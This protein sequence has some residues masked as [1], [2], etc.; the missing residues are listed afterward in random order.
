[1]ACPPATTEWT[2][3][4]RDRAAK[5]PRIFV[6]ENIVPQR[7]KRCGAG[8]HDTDTV[9]LANLL[10]QLVESLIVDCA[11][12]KNVD[13]FGGENLILGEGRVDRIGVKAMQSAFPGV[14]VLGEDGGNQTLSD[15]AFS[16]ED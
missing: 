16:L 2:K 6:F 3:T 13:V 1:M 8:I 14:E 11:A 10:H 4:R 15:A 7:D 5:K 9:E 12:T